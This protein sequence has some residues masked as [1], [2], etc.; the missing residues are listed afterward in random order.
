MSLFYKTQNPVVLI[1][2]KVADGTRTGV[3]LESTYST[4]EVVEPTK[5]IETAGYS[6]IVFD[7]NY[8]MGAAETTNSI[9]IKVEDS[10]DRI[11]WYRIPNDSASG[12]TSTLVAREWT[13][14]GTNAAAATISIMLDIAY[15]N[16][17]IS[18]K[19]TDVAANKGN[20]FVEATLSGL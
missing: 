13:F 16:I 6:K 4:T 11:N 14:V 19:E 17:R 15:R 1:G 5:S 9:Q 8:T 7:I 12:G 3:E 18:C 10:P 2:S 20:V